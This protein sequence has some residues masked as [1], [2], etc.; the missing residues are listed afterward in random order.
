[1]AEAAVAEV[2]RRALTEVLGAERRD[3]ILSALYL[4]RQDSVSV[5]RQASLR[6]WKALVH[7]TPRTGMLLTRGSWTMPELTS[8]FLVREILG[9]LVGQIVRLCSSDEYEQQE[10]GAFFLHP[11]T[12]LIHNW[13]VDRNAHDCRVVSQVWRKNLGRDHS[14]FAK[15]GHVAGCAYPSGCMPHAGGHDVRFPLLFF[16]AVSY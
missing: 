1:M 14:D 12:C 5:V 7:N 11:L 6:I 9:E 10:V 15:Q 16:K 8:V 2:S 4:A 3:R 13:D